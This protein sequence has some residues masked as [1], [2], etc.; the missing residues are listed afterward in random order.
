MKFNYIFTNMTSTLSQP[1]F[2][3]FTIYRVVIYCYYAESAWHDMARGHHNHPDIS[4]NCAT[5]VFQHQHIMQKMHINDVKMKLYLMTNRCAV[6]YLN[7]LS[8][9][10]I[11]AWQY[12]INRIIHAKIHITWHISP[13][14][15]MGPLWLTCNMDFTIYYSLCNTWMRVK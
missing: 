1:P 7:I 12:M 9:F 10:T 2:L 13:R 14:A 8:W 11:L 3:N 6:K 15:D 5:N 4:A